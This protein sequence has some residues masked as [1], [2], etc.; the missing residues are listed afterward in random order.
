MLGLLPSFPIVASLIRRRSGGRETSLDEPG[1]CLGLFWPSTTIACRGRRPERPNLASGRSKR[2]RYMLNQNEVI[3]S[4]KEGYKE[5]LFSNSGHIGVVGT[6]TLK[7]QEVILKWTEDYVLSHSSQLKKVFIAERSCRWKNAN[8]FSKGLAKLRQAHQHSLNRSISRQ[9]SA[10]V[11]LRA[12]TARIGA[13]PKICLYLLRTS[14]VY[15]LLGSLGN[16]IWS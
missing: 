2:K 14:P 1:M 15:L 10:Q 4:L 5:W 7:H 13:W 12:L 6:S 3:T 8:R 11:L 9:P 16:I